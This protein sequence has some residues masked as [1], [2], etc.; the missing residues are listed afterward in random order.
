MF[1]K[2]TG[3]RHGSQH[4]KLTVHQRILSNWTVPEITGCTDLNMGMSI[5]LTEICLS[6]THQDPSYHFKMNETFKHYIPASFFDVLDDDMTL[7]LLVQSHLSLTNWRVPLNM[8][9]IDICVDPFNVVVVQLVFNKQTDDLFK[10]CPRLYEN[11]FGHFDILAY[12]GKT[13][14]RFTL[15]PQGKV[16]LTPTSLLVAITL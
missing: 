14:N 15:Y 10:Y 7:R 13:P 4:E 9:R 6:L 2:I 3:S 12:V 5:D 16:Y 8:D 11:F 1:N